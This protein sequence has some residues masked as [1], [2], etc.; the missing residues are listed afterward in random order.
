MYDLGRN[1][2]PGNG[3]PE[4]RRRIRE[5]AEKDQQTAETERREANN[6]YNIEK[7]AA[8]IER[9][10]QK[11]DRTNDDK[12]PKRQ[13]IDVGRDLAFWVSGL[14]ALSVSPPFWL[15]LM[16]PASNAASCKDSSIRCNPP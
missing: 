9:V 12:L 1:M 14:R 6:K 8:A 16:T 5:K 15:A 10:G 11:L 2:L 7:I 4:Y 13:A 3:N